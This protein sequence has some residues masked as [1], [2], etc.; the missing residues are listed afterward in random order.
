MQSLNVYYFIFTVKYELNPPPHTSLSSQKPFPCTQILS[1]HL[2]LNVFLL[3]TFLGNNKNY[4]DNFFLKF[5]SWFLRK[6]ILMLILNYIS[7]L[8]HTCIA[9]SSLFY[10]MGYFCFTNS[11]FSSSQLFLSNCLFSS[12]RAIQTQP[13]G[14]LHWT[15]SKR[16][17][18]SSCCDDYR[19]SHF[20]E[21]GKKQ[22]PTESCKS[23]YTCLS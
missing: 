2:D 17:R 20:D 9:H 7:F 3:S 22:Q 1:H 4:Y 6:Y 18:P 21:R 5:L 16:Y 15:P 12:C 8:R 14:G 23:Q 19:C 13:N 10:S 11:E